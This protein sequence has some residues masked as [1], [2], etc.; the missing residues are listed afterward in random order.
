MK[1]A[2]S[3]VFKSIESFKEEKITKCPLED[4][5]RNS[6]I[7]CNTPAK[8]SYISYLILAKCQP[9]QLEHP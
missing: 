9:L 4:T 1:K 5:G 2:I 8:I 6:V 3:Y 7:P